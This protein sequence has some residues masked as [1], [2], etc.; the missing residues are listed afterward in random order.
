MYKIDFKKPI[1]IH[2][3]GIGGISMSGLAEILLKEN[4]QI[5]GSDS[6]ESELTDKLTALGASICYGQRASNITDNTDLVVYTAAIHPDNAELKAAVE[7]GIPTLTRAELLGQIMDNYK[8][9]IA[10]A[11]THGK[12]TTTSMITHILLHACADPTVSVGGIL[13]SIDGNIRVGNSSV[14]LTEACEYTN[15]FLNFYP[16]YAVILNIEED[17]LDFFKDLSDIRSSFHKFAENVP[18]DGTVI[19]NGQIDNYQEITQGLPCQIITY[20]LDASDSYYAD[21]ITFN[22]QGCGEFT[23]MHGSDSLG[24]ITLSVPGLHNVSNAVAASALALEMKF[25]FEHIKAALADFG[26]T[27]RRFEQKGSLGGITI[28]DDYAHHPT[29]IAATLKAAQNYPHER[30]V[31][32]FQP[33]TYTRTKAFLKDFAASLSHADIVVLADIYAARE[34]NTLGISSE[35]LLKELQALGCESYYFPSFDEIE[36]FLLKKCINGDLLIT[37]G[38]GD[39]VQ[40]GEHLLGH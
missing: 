28:I 11:G 16:K 39:I 9:S 38:A 30:V 20:G 32:V 15:S 40:V 19:I 31:C 14:F 7:K 6:K 13:K 37:M 23:L 2:F 29:E 18:A 3:I 22:T 36:N 21:N 24:T 1:H 25:S 4:F 35:D 27:A 26:G 33:H 17:H 12:T 10:V 5:S 8:N 34:K